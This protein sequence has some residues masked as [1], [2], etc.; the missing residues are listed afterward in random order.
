VAQILVQPLWLK[1]HKFRVAFAVAR[2]LT[3]GTALLSY[4]LLKSP[5]YLESPSQSSRALYDIDC[6]YI[7]LID[8][9]PPRSLVTMDDPASRVPGQLVLSCLSFPIMASIGAP[10]DK[11]FA[12]Y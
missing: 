1:G 9:Q 7:T 12:K 8:H 2:L 11:C 4:P 6:D 3:N 5:S 10:A